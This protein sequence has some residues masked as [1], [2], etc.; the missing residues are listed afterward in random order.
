M[1]YARVARRRVRGAAAA[2][3][4]AGM[5]VL[6]ACSDGGG[7]DD[8]ASAGPSGTPSASSAQD[9]GGTGGTRSPSG[10]LEGSWLTTAG[11]SAVA[12]VVTG[13][14]AALFGSKGTVC[15]GS[16]DAGSIRLTCAVGDDSRTSGTVDSVDGTTLKVTWD[17]GP[18]QETYQ[19]A[20]GGQLPSGLPTAGPGL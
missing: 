17:G 5:L 7:P 15:S 4:L 8:D 13:D 2:A 20:E 19:R 16:A 3:A 18:G 9:T 14:D 6:S 11:G 1:T 12:L 10:T